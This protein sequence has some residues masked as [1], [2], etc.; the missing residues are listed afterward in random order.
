MG[1]PDILI[2]IEGV[3]VFLEIKI[4]SD[5]LSKAQKQF[6]DEF[7]FTTFV[8]HYDPKN[9]KYSCIHSKKLKANESYLFMD[10]TYIVNSLNDLAQIKSKR[11]S[12]ISKN[13]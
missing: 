6:L 5:K 4:G 13:A 8:L 2:A 1:I 10:I 12:K 9:S 3:P 11:K 7:F